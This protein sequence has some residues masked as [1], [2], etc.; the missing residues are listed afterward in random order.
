MTTTPFRPLLDGHDAG[1]F[2]LPDEVLGARRA[3]DRADHAREA[4]PAPDPVARQAE[5]VE[6]MLGDDEPDPAELVAVESEQHAHELWQGLVREAREVA[7]RRLSAAIGENRDQIIV[8][9]LRTAHSESVEIARTLA[10]EAPLAD[11]PDVRIALAG[12]Q[13]HKADRLVEAARRYGAVRKAWSALTHGAQTRDLDNVF[14]ELRDLD[15]AWPTWRQHG[16]DRP[17]PATPAARLA[18]V[19]THAEPWLPTPA[20]QT[21]RWNE[22]FGDAERQAGRNRQQARA[23]GAVFQ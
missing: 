23:F 20:E 21:E 18:W 9:H 6:R 14:A 5:L 16:D 4:H 12:T 19:A 13:R 8:E 15:T 3:V 2:G 7:V 1:Y 11:N 10:A 17:W 22:V